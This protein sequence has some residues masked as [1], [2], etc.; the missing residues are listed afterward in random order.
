MISESAIKALAEKFQTTELNVQREYAQHLFLSYFYQQPASEQIFFKGGTALRVLY[1]SP[2]FS[3]DLDF[4]STVKNIQALEQTVLDTLSEIARQNIQTDIRESK[5][6][7]GGYLAILAFQMGDTPLS[8][9]LD[10]S[11]RES[12]K[13]G[14]VNTIIS[15][16]VP[17]YTIVNLVREQ[18]IDEKIQALL[19]RQKARDFYDLYFILRANLLSVKERELL[20]QASKTLTLSTIHFERELKPFLPKSHWALLRDFKKTLGREIERFL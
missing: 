16:F 9:Q 10:V 12:K 6:T 17:G 7:S 14:E 20:P 11:L 15:D 3:E 18:L 5:A 2:R 4:S 1:N 19:T 13:H 8:I